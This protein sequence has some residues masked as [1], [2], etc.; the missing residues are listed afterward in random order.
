MVSENLETR[1]DSDKTLA[2]RLHGVNTGRL[3]CSFAKD[4][5]GWAGLKLLV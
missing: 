2:D 4:G 3:E 1:S 5:L